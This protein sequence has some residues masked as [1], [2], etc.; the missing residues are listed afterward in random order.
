M[1]DQGTSLNPVEAT[2]SKYALRYTHKSGN[3]ELQ[4]LKDGAL[5][6]KM[7]LMVLKNKSVLSVCALDVLSF[8]CNIYKQRIY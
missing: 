3:R 5:P 2:L 7:V 8:I 4:E 6:L 1:T